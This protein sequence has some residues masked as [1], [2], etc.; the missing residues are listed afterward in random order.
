MQLA[1]LPGLVLDLKYRIERQ[2]GEGSMGAVFQATHLGT[3]RPVAVKVIVPQFAGSDEFAQR[4]KR[5]AEAAGR[6]SHPNVV[7]VTDFGVTHAAGQELAYLV[8]EYLDGQS[9]ADYLKNNP[10]PPFDVVLDSMEQTGLA[11]DALHAVGIV[12]RDL[13]PSN[14]WLEPNHRGGFILKVLDFGIAKVANASG[15]QAQRPDVVATAVM[16]PDAMTVKLTMNVAGGSPLGTPSN[17]KTIAGSILGTPAYMAPEQCTGLGVDPRSDVYS[18]AVIA[19]EMLCGCV[20]FEADTLGELM[21]RQIQ[22]TPPSAS[23]RDATVPRALAD[24][25]STGLEKD[26]ER[27]PSTAGTFAAR[28]RAASDGETALVRKS[29]DIFHMHPRQFMTALLACLSPLLLV[30]PLRL[31]AGRAAAA[32]RPQGPLLIGLAVS[33]SLLL[34]LGFQA[35]KAVTALMLR[36]ASERGRFRSGAGAAMKTLISGFGGFLK[37]QLASAADLRPSSWW[38]NMLWPVVWAM[39]GRSGTD[40]VARSR[41]LCSTLRMASASLAVRQYS[42]VVIGPMMMPALMALLDPTGELLAFLLK[43]I[44]GGGPF[45]WF[46]LLYPFMAGVMFLNYAPAFS[47]LYWSALRCRNEGTEVE[48]PPISRDYSRKSAART[49]RPATI[50]W[51]IF[52]LALLAILSYR[53]ISSGADQR[54]TEASTDGRRATVLRLVDGGMGVNWKESDGETPIF[55]AIRSEDGQLFTELLRRG[56]NVNAQNRFGM[57]PL[58]TAAQVGRNDLARTLIDHGALVD[59]F[60]SDGRT[61]LMEATMRGNRTLADLLLQHGAST[62]KLDSHGKS[63]AAYAREEGYPDLATTLSQRRVK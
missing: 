57:T 27:R 40:A 48:L 37:T 52:T 1:S 18:M 43:R 53:L 21:R 51:I 56:A 32:H 10:R 15:E 49:L 44:L 47:F 11:L 30:I 14:I 62:E 36:Y 33:C 23:E 31:A 29:K 20:P 7:N 50:G 2:L 12:H 4:F 17:V 26:P 54:L 8:M 58:I 46:A 3:M 42:L 28:L 39:E 9:L 22:S 25:V 41:E 6:L 35:F 38:A 63:A 24:V 59:P 60:N 61:A 19:Y 5:E 13:K 16:T 45:G 55:E 34:V